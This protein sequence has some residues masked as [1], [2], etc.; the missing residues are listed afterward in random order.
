MKGENNNVS[1]S[2]YKVQIQPSPNDSFDGLPTKLLIGNRWVWSD[3][4]YLVR[5]SVYC[6]GT[7]A[8]IQETL[9]YSQPNNIEN[10]CV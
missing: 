5:H 6:M 9:Q 3:R 10:H 8:L 4:R 2:Y 1:N 7:M